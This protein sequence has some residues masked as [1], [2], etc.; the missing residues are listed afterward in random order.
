MSNGPSLDYDG[1]SSYDCPKK[2]LLIK[3]LKEV[4]KINKNNASLE[5]LTT[6][7]MSTGPSLYYV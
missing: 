6:M 7:K 4:K 3:P 5:N 1:Y 2:V